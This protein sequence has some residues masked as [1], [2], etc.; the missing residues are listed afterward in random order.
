[1]A[2]RTA[3]SSALRRRYFDDISFAVYS[4]GGPAI[5]TREIGDAPG[6][7]AKN[8]NLAGDLT[9][10][11]I[12]FDMASDILRTVSPNIVHGD[13]IIFNVITPRAGAALVGLPKM[14]YKIKC[15]P[16]FTDRVRYARANGYIEG[17]VDGG[18]VYTSGGVL[19]ADRYASTSRTGT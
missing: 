16:L 12:R 15:N 7:F 11:A 19:I 14:H 5:S 10:N 4:Y 18:P 3:P 2:T 6:Q 8:L 9:V 1:M 17:E 13:S